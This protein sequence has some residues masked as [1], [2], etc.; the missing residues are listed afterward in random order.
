MINF[1]TL[2]TNTF[3]ESMLMGTNKVKVVEKFVLVDEFVNI[4]WCNHILECLIM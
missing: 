4:D 2:F 3:I 1:M